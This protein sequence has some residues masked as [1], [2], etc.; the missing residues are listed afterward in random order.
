MTRS[1]VHLLSLMLKHGLDITGDEGAAALIYAMMGGN[2]KICSLLI[3]HRAGIDSSQ[4]IP[5]LCCS[6][7]K[8]QKF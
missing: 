8:N 6:G 4:P 1:H 2:K 7:Y 5:K 3:A